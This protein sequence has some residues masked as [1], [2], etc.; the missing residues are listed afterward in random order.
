[1]DPNQPNPYPYPAPQP[2][3][4][5]PGY[6]PQPPAY[7]EYG[8]PQYQQQQQLTP[9]PY[10]TYQAPPPQ[11]GDNTYQ[12]QHVAYDQYGNP[13]YYQPQAP[14]PA[15]APPQPA[16]YQV[17]QHSDHIPPR[18]VSPEILKSHEES[19][20]KYP[21]LNLT[22]DEY[23]LA[24]VTR[25]PVGMFKIWLGA[26][27]A[28][29]AFMGLYLT[30]FSNPNSAL[31]DMASIAVAVLAVMIVLCVIG[32]LV[33]SLIYNSNRLF[34]TNESIIE[35]TQRTLLYK[36]EQTVGLTQ[37]EDASYTQRGVLPLLF[38]YGTIQFSTEGDET[39]YIFTYAP[40]PERLV[41]IANNALEASKTGKPVEMP[42]EH[43]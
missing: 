39:T 34:I 14:V 8:D 31:A 37:V 19:L 38:N 4:P 41:A 21:H 15:P 3:Q 5:N 36:H 10:L 35:E 33:M 43:I 30:L 2:P 23:I 16:T 1:M 29:M 22:E 32:T 6:P 42:K 7:D 18:P 13:L 12:P 27:V 24:V 25:H 11:P 40:N 28:M 20:K 17:Q 9:N 26:L